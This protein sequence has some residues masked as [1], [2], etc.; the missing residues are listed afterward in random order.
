MAAEIGRE[1]ADADAVMGI[2]LRRGQRAVHRRGLAVDP[3]QPGR[4]L[5]RRVVVQRQRRQRAAIRRSLRLGQAGHVKPGRGPGRHALP[6]VDKVLLDVGLVG[7][8]HQRS[9]QFLGRRAKP[10]LGFQHAA[11]LVV[12]HLPQRRRW[13]GGAPGAQRRLGLTRRLQRRAKVDRRLCHVGFQSQRRAV[14]LGRASRIAG[15]HPRDA[16]IE[17]G[18]AGRTLAP[19]AASQIS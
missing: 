12:Q 6:H 10:A 13:Q 14:S 19:W 2:A 1:V 11:K 8:D 7:R 16:K 3:V 18:G 17:P 4:R 15:L 5:Q 9:P